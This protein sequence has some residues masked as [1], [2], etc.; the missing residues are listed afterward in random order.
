MKEIIGVT[1][2][3]PKGYVER[4]FEGKSVFI[5]PA[6]CFKEIKPGMKLIFYRSREETGYVGEATITEILFDTD[7]NTFFEAYGDAIFLSKDELSQYLDDQVRWKSVRVR[8]KEIKKKTWMALKL[9]NI[10]QYKELIK[11]DRFVPV[12]GQYIKE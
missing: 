7:P 11:P 3:I 2:P 5:K 10:K 9:S 8:K 6:N 12:G 4:F 1:F